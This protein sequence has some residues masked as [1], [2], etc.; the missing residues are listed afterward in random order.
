MSSL[1]SMPSPALV[2]AAEGGT[3]EV[4]TTTSGAIGLAWLIPVLPLLG[5]ALVL[6][7]ARTLRER[8][9]WIAVA[10]AVGSFVLSVL[11]FFQVAGDPAAHVRPIADFLVIGPFEVRWELLVDQLTTVMLLVVTGV[12]SL[13]HIYSIGYMEHDERRRRFFGLSGLQSPQ[14]GPSSGTP[15]EPPQP[16]MVTFTRPP[17]RTAC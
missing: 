2:L 15:P 16:R 6:L 17:C 1:Y 14:C 9:A 10:A 5:F 7:A 12:G 3:N 11:V 8:A 13:I 4:V